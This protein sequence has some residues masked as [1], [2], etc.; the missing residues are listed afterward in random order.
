M[1]S[2]SRASQSEDP[3]MRSGSTLSDKRREKLAADGVASHPLSA[4][5]SISVIGEESVQA[6][7]H[8]LNIS[9]DALVIIDE[10]GTITFINTQVETL[11]GYSRSELLGHPLEL[12]LP[13][14][15]RTS[16]AL[17]RQ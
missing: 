17:H 3:P 9:P 15:L 8:W 10:Q 6:F 7:Q 12:L 5:A 4:L 14:R 13:E 11:F 16:H 2:T 1:S